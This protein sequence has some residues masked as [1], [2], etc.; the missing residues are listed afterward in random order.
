MR[1][2]LVSYYLDFFNNYMT[3]EKFAEHNG[4]TVDQANQVIKLG[5]EIHESKHPES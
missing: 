5:K 3:V 4:I 2:T 1:E